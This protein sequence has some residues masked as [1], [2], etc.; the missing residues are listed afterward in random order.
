MILSEHPKVAVIRLSGTYDADRG[1]QLEQ[2]LFEAH[3]SDVALLDMR[4]V[5][6]IDAS[7]CVRLAHLK[8]RMRGLTGL[9]LVGADERIWRFLRMLGLHRAFS[10][11][12]TLKSALEGLGIERRAM[13]SCSPMRR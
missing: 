1:S 12:D 11:Y 5:T 3:G 2:Q 10:R 4:D 13:R 9:R 6:R 7:C 8:K